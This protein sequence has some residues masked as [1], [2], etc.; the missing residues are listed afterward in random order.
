MTLLQDG[1]CAPQRLVVH[2]VD[3][4]GVSASVAVT[5]LDA[6]SDATCLVFL[7]VTQ[8]H[9]PR[10][11]FVFELVQYGHKYS[12]YTIS[13]SKGFTLVEL[14]VVMSIMTLASIVITSVGAARAGAC[15]LQTS[16]E[17]MRGQASLVYNDTGS[18]VCVIAIL[19]RLSNQSG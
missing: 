15:S 16:D 14:L 1:S 18:L 19:P 17:H 6:D 5:A 9:R 12:A 7:N 2:G 8:K 11:V 10:G 4:T 3:S 13:Q